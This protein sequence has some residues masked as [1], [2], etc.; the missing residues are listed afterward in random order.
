M[1][2]ERV[3]IV[4]ESNTKHLAYLVDDI[5]EFVIPINWLH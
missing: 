1:K 5:I 4:R 3:E 2:N